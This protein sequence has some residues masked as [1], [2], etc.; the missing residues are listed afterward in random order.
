[1]GRALTTNGRLRLSKGAISPRALVTWKMTI[2]LQTS[3]QMQE[4]WVEGRSS[5]QGMTRTPSLM[6]RLVPLVGGT[7]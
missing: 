2:G 3:K 4:I 7:H 6:A 1:M 5:P